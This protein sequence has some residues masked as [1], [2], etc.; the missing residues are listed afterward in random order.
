MATGDDAALLHEL[1]GYLAATDQTPLTD[2]QKDG[3]TRG[4]YCLKDRAKTFPDLLDKAHFILSSRPLD[5]EEKAAKNL[6]SVSRSIL[7]E[8]TPQLQNASWDRDTLEGLLN[9]LAESHEIKFGKLAGP[10]RAALAGRAATP[11]VFDM[12]LVLGRDETLAR[13]TDAGS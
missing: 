10:L 6:D 7:T 1:G 13:L 11:S 4:L 3:M 9:A 2:D 5:I 8:L 12:M